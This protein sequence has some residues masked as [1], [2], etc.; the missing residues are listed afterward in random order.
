MGSSSKIIDT[1]SFGRVKKCSWLFS[2]R[3]I[4]V[5]VL[6]LY[7]WIQ[8]NLLH[9]EIFRLTG[10]FKKYLEYIRS[11]YLWSHCWLLTDICVWASINSNLSF[12]SHCSGNI[13]WNWNL[14]IRILNVWFISRERRKFSNN[15][16]SWQNFLLSKWFISWARYQ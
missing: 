9:V 16:P 4:M 1:H 3:F 2:I 5:V 12:W 7:I 15:P 13:Y 6:S 8:Q 14:P 10:L 11:C